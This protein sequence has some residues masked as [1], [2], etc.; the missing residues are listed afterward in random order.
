MQPVQVK[1]SG[2]TVALS[3]PALVTEGDMTL[4]TSFVLNKVAVGVI[5]H[6]ES[7]KAKFQLDIFIF[8]HRD[9]F[10]QRGIEFLER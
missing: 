7:I 6:V 1:K 8:G 4:S 10:V 5:E 9:G 2:F 3:D